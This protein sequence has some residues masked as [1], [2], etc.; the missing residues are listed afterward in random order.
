M[1]GKGVTRIDT[2]LANAAGNHLTQLVWYNYIVS[3]GYDHV[4]ICMYLDLQRF[5]D[6]IRTVDMP[7]V[8]KIPD[9]KPRCVCGR[10]KL[11][12]FFFAGC[13]SKLTLSARS[14]SGCVHSGTSSR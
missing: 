7:N 12:C 5:N 4:A 10:L 6:T 13:Y 9:C 2:I 11:I 3:K 8:L 14:K 1:N